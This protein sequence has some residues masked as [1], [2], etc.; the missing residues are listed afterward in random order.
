MQNQC[1]DFCICLFLIAEVCYDVRMFFVRWGAGQGSGW[2]SFKTRF[3]RLVNNISYKSNSLREFVW[4]QSFLPPARVLWAV[5]FKEC[6]MTGHPEGYD[7]GRVLWSGRV[8][9]SLINRKGCALCRRP[10]G[11]IEL[12]FLLFARSRVGRFSDFLSLENR[13]ENRESFG[14]ITYPELG[15]WVR[16]SGPDLSSL[17]T[18]KHS[19][20][21]E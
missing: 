21:A 7:F 8:L 3:P 18:W 5:V 19:L 11:L 12:R 4:L 17:N 15:I 9:G 10:L 20:I 2:R 16:W 14:D 13:F 1:Q 6:M